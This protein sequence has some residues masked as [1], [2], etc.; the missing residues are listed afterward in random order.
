MTK[1]DQKVPV[2]EKKGNKL[3]M[4]RGDLAPE[5]EK[6][7]RSPEAKF[8]TR[9]ALLKALATILGALIGGFA[10]ALALMISAPIEQAFAGLFGVTTGTLMTA[11]LYFAVIFGIVILLFFL[12]RRL[13]TLKNEAKANNVTLE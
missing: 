4:N 12:T 2:L 11:L 10:F 13:N 6:K 8:I 3:F 9:F 1:D 5:K 7:A